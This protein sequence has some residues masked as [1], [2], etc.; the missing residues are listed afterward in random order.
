MDMALLVGVEA[1][2]AQDEAID[3]GHWG[4]RRRGGDWSR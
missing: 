3:D 2:G 4:I 1:G